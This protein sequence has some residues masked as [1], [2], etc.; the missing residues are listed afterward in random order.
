MQRTGF[1]EKCIGRCREMFPNRLFFLRDREVDECRRLHLFFFRPIE[2]AVLTDFRER[3]SLDLR[4][5]T[6]PGG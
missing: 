4:E 1:L 3:K 6:I 5:S 2:G